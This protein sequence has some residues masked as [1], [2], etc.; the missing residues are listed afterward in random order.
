MRKSIVTYL[1]AIVVVFLSATLPAYGQNVNTEHSSYSALHDEE[2]AISRY[3]L[4]DADTPLFS[5]YK[6]LQNGYMPVAYT[7]HGR[8]DQCIVVGGVELSDGIVRA[9]VE[10]VPLRLRTQKPLA[11]SMHLG[12]MF[13]RRN[14]VLNVY[15]ARGSIRQVGAMALAGGYSASVKGRFADVGSNGGY[16]IAFRGYFGPSVFGGGV[17]GYGGLL[18]AAVRRGGLSLLLA[19][20]PSVKSLR[21]ASVDEAFE[22]THNKLYNPSV[23]VDRGRVRNARVRRELLPVVV[24]NYQT[25]LS[26]DTKFYG[27]VMGRAGVVSRSGVDWYNGL[28]PYPDHY[29]S[30]PSGAQSEWA[31]EQLRQMWSAKETEVSRIDWTAMRRM[32]QIN[33]RAQ[34]V[35]ASQVERI[36]SAAGAVGIAGSSSESRYRVGV[37]LRYDNS[38]FYKRIDD[39][40]GAQYAANIDFF[41]S[42]LSAG[43]IIYN[44]TANPDARLGVGD[45]SDYNYTINRLGAVAVGEWVWQREG[46]HAGVDMRG[47]V[48][49]LS[50]RGL[51]QRSVR[52]DCYGRSPQTPFADCAIELEGGYSWSYHSLGVAAWVATLVPEYDNIYLTPQNSSAQV[53]NPSSGNDYGVRGEYILSYEGIAAHI[54]VS[55][56]GSRGES[57]VLRYYDDLSGYYADM[58]MRDIRTR[59]VGVDLSVDGAINEMWM[60]SVAV[61]W[62]REVYA[63]NPMVRIYADSDGELLAQGGSA[64][65][66]MRTGSTPSLAAECGLTARFVGGWSANCS[67]TA[68]CGRYIVPNPLYRMERVRV[69]ATSPEEYAFISRGQKLGNT[70][71][72]QLG[73][74]KA[75]Y[76]AGVVVSLSVEGVVA[77][78]RTY[79]AYEQMR[80]R[81][82]TDGYVGAPLKRMYSLPFTAFL[83]IT[84]T[85]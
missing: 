81:H 21:G 52:A 84:Y 45:R 68:L 3:E 37:E 23:G 65:Q 2:S 72:A 63:N 13:G 15:D 43:S 38:A 66:G 12:E 29:R 16:D 27:S 8:R 59:R 34:Y 35:V 46:W 19:V 17:D 47:G 57:N 69:S 71:C 24:A 42:E 28:S 79:Y 80:L 61:S 7:F 74:S 6:S 44:D 73:L 67:A 39:L 49:L 26:P 50:R 32:N 78:D 54:G 30:L 9:S 36:I 56:G 14:Y 31:A 18:T 82:N 4:F 20:A 53:G 33:G 51:W 83:S 5:S 60:L 1:C 58:E 10:T 64:L 70:L 11:D 48:K 85:L 55:A 76:D 40:L 75:F 25:Q 41:E 62:L 22:L 77:G